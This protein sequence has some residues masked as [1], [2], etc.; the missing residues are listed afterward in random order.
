MGLG[1]IINGKQMPITPFKTSWAGT[2]IRQQ[3]GCPRCVHGL[4]FKCQQCW[5][6]EV[7]IERS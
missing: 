5:S 1:P 6:K 7:R 2:Q 3:Q 4:G